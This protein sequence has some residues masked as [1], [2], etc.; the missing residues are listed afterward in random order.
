MNL[1]Q[2]KEM[3]DD[4]HWKH[5]AFTQRM[6][7]SQWKKILLASE[8]RI[9][10]KGE[11]VALKAKNLGFGVVEISKDFKVPKTTEEDKT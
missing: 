3:L 6:T 10:F 11:I 1:S 4:C 2:K 7:T 9:I 8:D 5:R